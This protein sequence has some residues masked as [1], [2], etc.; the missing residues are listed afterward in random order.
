MHLHNLY[1]V[2]NFFQYGGILDRLSSPFEVLAPECCLVLRLI[3]NCELGDNY[4]SLVRSLMSNHYWN[5]TI[6]RDTVTVTKN[7]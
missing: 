5:F 3:V 4:R 6:I 2:I 1:C 7:H